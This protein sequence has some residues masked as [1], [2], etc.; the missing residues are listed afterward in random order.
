MRV[1][2]YAERG[3]I[4]RNEYTVSDLDWN[5]EST[6]FGINIETCGYA[7]TAKALIRIKHFP[8][9]E[10]Y[11]RPRENNVLQDDIQFNRSGDINDLLLRN[12]WEA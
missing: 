7:K 5:W 10:I 4:S 9:V 11:Q 12:L 1:V 3:M 6:G 8:Y 2:N